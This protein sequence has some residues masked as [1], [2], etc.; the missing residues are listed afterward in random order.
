MEKV[1][2]KIAVLSMYKNNL[3]CKSM[4]SFLYNGNAGLKWQCE[5]MAKDKIN[6]YNCLL[7]NANFSVKTSNE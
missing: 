4:R 2:F 6:P 1:A 5:C 3:Q 7:K